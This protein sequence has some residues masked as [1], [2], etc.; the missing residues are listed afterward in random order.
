[1]R[2][3]KWSMILVLATLLMAC[4][5]KNTKPVAAQ[6][7]T[8]TSSS[9]QAQSTG[10]GIE[11]Q[12][13][14]SLTP[15]QQQSLAQRTVLFGFDKTTVESS[16]TPMLQAHAGYLR[17]HAQQSILLAGNTDERGSREYNMGLG[18]R[19]AKSVAD[20]L[21]ANGVLANQ[22]VKISYGP[23]V[24]VGCGHSDDAYAKNRRVDLVYCDTPDCQNVAK[25]YAQYK[26]CNTH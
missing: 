26:M 20:V 5:T 3:I 19:R 13:D 17:D 12:L 9:E 6:P 2:I 8:S 14:S 7:T 11:P 1:M 10:L 21:M 18:E 16:Y 4:A 25:K 23:E 22:I 15:E 24:P